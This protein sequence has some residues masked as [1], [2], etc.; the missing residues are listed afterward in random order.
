MHALDNELGFQLPNNAVL[1]RRARAE[2][3]TKLIRF[4]LSSDS[5]YTTGS[6]YQVDGGEI[7]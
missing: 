6:V 5:S 7:C 2:E 3:V 4:L 1:G